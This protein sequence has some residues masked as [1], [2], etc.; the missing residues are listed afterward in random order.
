M[1]PPYFFNEARL[2]HVRNMHC[3]SLV[4]VFLRSLSSQFSRSRKGGSL[5]KAN[6]D[7]TGCL[8]IRLSL[9]DGKI[10][11]TPPERRTCRP[12]ATSFTNENS[13][14]LNGE[15]AQIFCG[16]FQGS[17]QSQTPTAVTLYFSWNVIFASQAPTIREHRHR[18]AAAWSSVLDT[19]STATSTVH[20]ARMTSVDQHQHRHLASSSARGSAQYS[21]HAVR[22]HRINATGELI[23]NDRSEQYVIATENIQRSVRVSWSNAHLPIPRRTRLAL[24]IPPVDHLPRSTHP[25]RHFHHSPTFP[26]PRPTTSWT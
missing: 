5:K 14:V 10:P 15:Q 20:D 26:I 23:I 22:P 21:A 2:N 9:A 18:H 11:A 7:S 4:I 17:D 16:S 24:P 3:G 1:P 12:A 25:T 6:A 8:P 19:T 13:A